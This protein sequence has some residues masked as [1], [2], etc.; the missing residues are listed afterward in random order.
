MTLKI[1]WG[2]LS[3]VISGGQT[4]ADQGGLIAAREFGIETGGVAPLHY[5]T[6]TG[7]CPL[8]MAFGLTN[9]GTYETRTRDNVW[10]SGGT[11]VITHDHDSPGSKLTRAICVAEGKPFINIDIKSILLGIEDERSSKIFER[12]ERLAEFVEQ[13][14]VSILNV[15]GNREIK[16]QFVPNRVTLTTV[17]LLSATFEILLEKGLL[18]QEGDIF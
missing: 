15:A 11:V 7:P 8:L 5:L 17:D 9:V 12:A 14:Q 4:G 16:D 10:R 6:S 3:K 13:H 18:L 2:G 1:E